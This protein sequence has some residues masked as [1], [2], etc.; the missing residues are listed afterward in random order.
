M[1][2]KH[3]KLQSNSLYLYQ[4][5]TD[6]QL[7]DN[8]QNRRNIVVYAANLVLHKDVDNALFFQ[9]KNSDQRR[10]PIGNMD[11]TFVVFDERTAEQQI[12]FELPLT[13]IDATTGKAS[14]T[15][16]EQFLYHV[17]TGKYEYAITSLELDGTKR[18]TYVDDN[19][20]MRGVV[21][22]K[23]GASPI[24]KASEI[25]TFDSQT[26][27]TDV[28]SGLT[29]VHNNNALHTVLMK[30]TTFTGDMTI[31]ATMDNIM[32]QTTNVTWFDVATFNYV[33][34]DDN[35]TLNFNGVFS[36]VR[37]VQAVTTGTI[38]ELQYRF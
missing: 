30:F 8:T 37:F 26:D 9:F 25:L 11:F 33:A 18:P 3:I 6:V 15:V 21:D 35:V 17:E 36:G 19:L 5:K 2:K 4:N 7:S 1:L 16:P 23:A 24:F 27:M 14:V 20:G 12:L 31:Q 32:Q 28:V 34:Q 38:D 22:I 13:I 29:Q 10:V